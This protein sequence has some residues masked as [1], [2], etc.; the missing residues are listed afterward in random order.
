VPDTW[1]TLGS[2]RG[3]GS[4]GPSLHLSKLPTPDSFAMKTVDCAVVPSDPPM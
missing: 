3:S 2:D 4:G 1:M